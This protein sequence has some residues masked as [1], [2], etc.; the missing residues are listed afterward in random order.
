MERPPITSDV[1]GTPSESA[2]ARTSLFTHST[3]TAALS[4]NDFPAF[5]Y[6]K[7][8]RNTGSGANASSNDTSDAWLADEPAPG[9]RTTPRMV[10]T[11]SPEECGAPQKYQ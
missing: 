8:T 5:R 10:V 9:N 7:S 1:V 6:G 3:N 11:S 4:G 2:N